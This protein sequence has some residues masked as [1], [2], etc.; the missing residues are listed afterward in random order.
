MQHFFKADLDFGIQHLL[1]KHSLCSPATQKQEV[2]QDYEPK[3]AKHRG[4]VKACKINGKT[5]ILTKAGPLQ[6]GPFTLDTLYFPARV[7]RG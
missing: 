5:W 4:S 1:E 6:F 7:S 3:G 2:T